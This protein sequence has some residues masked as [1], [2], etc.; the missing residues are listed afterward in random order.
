MLYWLFSSVSAS[1]YRHPACSD[2]HLL[3]CHMW[4]SHLFTS[5]LL[6]QLTV[7]LPCLL[8]NWRISQKCCNPC[9][10]PLLLGQMPDRKEK[11]GRTRLFHARQVGNYRDWVNMGAKEEREV[12]SFRDLPFWGVYKEMGTVVSRRTLRKPQVPHSFITSDT[13]P[14]DSW[15][16]LQ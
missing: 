1:P 15:W 8:F 7:S 12:R 11:E 9:C 4:A 13:I 6:S 16:L 14:D 10:T 5:P 2:C 3:F